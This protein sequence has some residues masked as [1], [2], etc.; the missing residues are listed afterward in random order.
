LA[1]RLLKSLQCLKNAVGDLAMCVPHRVTAQGDSG[2]DAAN[3]ASYQN[4]GKGVQFDGLK[5][6]TLRVRPVRA[7]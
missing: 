2:R 4:A 6:G 7:F 1:F 3:Q 5:S